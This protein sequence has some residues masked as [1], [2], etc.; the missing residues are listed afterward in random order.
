LDRYRRD[1]VLAHQYTL[2]LFVTDRIVNEEHVNEAR[3][4]PS[5][6]DS[7]SARSVAAAP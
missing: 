6:D 4:Q 7:N 3:K 5:S 2:K 1:A